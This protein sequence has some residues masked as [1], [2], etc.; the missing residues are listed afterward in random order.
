MWSN[1]RIKNTNRIID[2]DLLRAQW[3]KWVGDFW[4]S[5]HNNRWWEI[6][7]HLVLHRHFHK[8]WEYPHREKSNVHYL[9]W[10]GSMLQCAPLR[11]RSFIFTVLLHHVETLCVLFVHIWYVLSAWGQ[12]NRSRRTSTRLTSYRIAIPTVLS[13]NSLDKSWNEEQDEGL[14]ETRW[15]RILFRLEDVVLVADDQ[16]SIVNYIIYFWAMN[17]TDLGSDNHRIVRVSA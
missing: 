15:K 5:E 1:R 17:A 16:L 3:I 14:V 2:D 12:C 4:A 11:R 6:I 9:N 7:N 10:M 13:G 8:C